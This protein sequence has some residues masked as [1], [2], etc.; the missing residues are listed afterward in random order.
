MRAIVLCNPRAGRRGNEESIAD[1]VNVL[2]RAGWSIDLELS[3]G[4]GNITQLA[5]GAAAEG[6]DAVL[7]A[8]GDGTL[9]EAVQGLAGTNTALGYLPYGT[10]NV[11]AREIGLPMDP[12]RAARAMVRGRDEQIDLGYANGR[13]FLLM[14]GVGLDGE[15]VR[16]AQSVE[17]H[18]QRFGVL[19]Y[20]AVSLS[21]VPL[22]RGADLELRYDGVIRRVQALMLVIGNSRLY[23]GR[24]QLTPHAVMNDGWLDVC[25]VKGRGPLAVVR[26]SLPLLLSRTMTRGDVEMF[27]VREMSV[28]GDSPLPYQVDGELAGATP[29]R[30]TIEPRVLRVI[31]PEEFASGLIA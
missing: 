22:Y 9:N 4:P 17:H 1:A 15:V 16:R 24:F 27:R 14:A 31:V 5:A 19:P 13:A 10:V 23:A 12:A 3:D 26:Q 18:K 29:V 11:W 30:F 21:T 6:M 7:V 20:I 8:G 28:V 25:I 2:E